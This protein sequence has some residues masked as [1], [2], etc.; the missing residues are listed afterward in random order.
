M[1][2]RWITDPDVTPGEVSLPPDNP[3]WKEECPPTKLRVVRP[4]PGTNMGTAAPWSNWGTVDPHDCP[5]GGQQYELP[6]TV[7]ELI[8]E[9]F[10]E[11]L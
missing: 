6:K 2:G 4:I 11:A 8:D 9:G 5:G 3:G 7:Q 1:D 10:I